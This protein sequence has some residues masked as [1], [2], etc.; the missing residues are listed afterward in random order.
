M[1]TRICMT[2]L[3]FISMLAGFASGQTRTAITIGGSY[4]RGSIDY[5]GYFEKYSIASN[6]IGPYLNIRINKVSIGGSMFLG[7]FD[8]S[9]ETI[10]EYADYYGVFEED[11]D[12]TDKLKRNDINLSLGYSLS[13]NI[14]LFG[15]YKSLKMTSEW[16][17][18]Y[19]GFVEEPKETS[20]LTGSFIGGGLSAMFPLGRTSPL[21][22]FG[23]VAYM[24]SSGGDI[25]DVN[26]VAASFGLGFYDRSGF[27]IMAGYRTDEFQSKED[28]EDALKIK[29]IMATVA[30]TIR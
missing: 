23:S 30:Y 20:D 8:F 5:E 14:S 11:L 29:G 12:I 10:K 22:I 17:V 21:F 7:T 26:L 9:S 19:L 13:R 2:I 3:L 15:A 24:P 6:M 16:E 28:S 18:N 4:W 27:S 25:E 1:K